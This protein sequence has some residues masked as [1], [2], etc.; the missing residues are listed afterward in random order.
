MTAVL[1]ALL[2]VAALIGG[3]LLTRV[4]TDENNRVGATVGILATVSGGGVV[5]LAI[6]TP[7]STGLVAASILCFGVVATTPDD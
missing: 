5:A 7:L 2:G 6:G 3:I 4:A 1:T